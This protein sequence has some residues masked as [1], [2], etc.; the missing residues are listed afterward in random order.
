MC[1]EDLEPVGQVRREREA[2]LRRLP[3]L[4]AHR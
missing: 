4:A 3:E 2:Q 1:A